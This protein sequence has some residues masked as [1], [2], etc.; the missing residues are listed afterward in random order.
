MPTCD[1]AGI[2]V[3]RLFSRSLAELSFNDAPSAEF[4]LD[5][6]QVELRPLQPRAP[7]IGIVGA[8][9]FNAAV[10]R[11]HPVSCALQVEESV[12]ARFR[13]RAFLPRRW[14]GAK[15]APDLP[16]TDACQFFRHLSLN[17]SRTG[18][19]Q[20]GA[21]RITWR[22]RCS[23]QPSL[24]SIFPTFSPLNNFKNAVGAFSMPCSTVSFR[25][26]LPSRIHPDMSF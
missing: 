12:L 22:N 4:R 7:S 1:I 18:G 8:V 2:S 19:H 25:V 3:M 9:V 26:S 21:G 13:A 16:A 20:P 23:R 17:F 24:T 5:C 10:R 15:H 14:M 11:I 6:V